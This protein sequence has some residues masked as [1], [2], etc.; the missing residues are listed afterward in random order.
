MYVYVSGGGYTRCGVGGDDIDCDGGVT[1]GVGGMCVRKGQLFVAGLAEAM[2]RSLVR[3]S[4]IAPY[5]NSREWGMR[6]LRCLWRICL[7]VRVLL[8]KRK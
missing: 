8:F 5:L 4:Q 2:P 7:G 3:F 6:I 1:C